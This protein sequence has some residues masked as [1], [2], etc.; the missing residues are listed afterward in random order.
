MP[1]SRAPSEP[2]SPRAPSESANGEPTIVES[3]LDVV[4]GFCIAIAA[5]A[6]SGIVQAQSSPVAWSTLIVCAVILTPFACFAGFV[7]TIGLLCCL[8][9]VAIGLLCAWLPVLIRKACNLARAAA[10]KINSMSEFAEKN[11]V[12]LLG[13]GVMALPLLPVLIVGVAIAG[14]G[15]LCLAPVTVP[16]TLY[17]LYRWNLRPNPVADE[18]AGKASVGNGAA[19]AG[20]GTAA[21]TAAA[22][23]QSSAGER[24]AERRPTQAPIA[25]RRAANPSAGP[26]S[27]RGS[28]RTSAPAARAERSQ[29]PQEPVQLREV[30]EPGHISDH[31]SEQLREVREPRSGHRASAA[32]T[33]LP[34]SASCR[35]PAASCRAPSA[36]CRAQ[37]ASCRAPSASLLSPSPDTTL[38]SPSPAC[39]TEG[40]RSRREGM[41]SPGYGEEDWSET[42]STTRAPSESERAR[43]T[44][45]DHISNHISEQSSSMRPQS[46]HISDHISD[47]ISEQSSSMRPQSH[48]ISDHI[49]D[50]ISEQSSSMRPLAVRLP[51]GCD[52]CAGAP[53]GSANDAAYLASA[54]DAAYLASAV[55]ALAAHKVA[56]MRY[57]SSHHGRASSAAS[58]AFAVAN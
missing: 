30:R 10:S 33:Q 21:G 36:S 3:A 49:S 50:H 27:V 8:P 37:S 39:A 7:M 19:A 51:V 53:N 41:A 35:A 32:V 13:V 45:S 48:H 58:S 56:E 43:L 2:A 40:T 57:A 6:C 9:V 44:P 31:F 29:P 20:N 17:L 25:R 11:P 15:Y 55:R 16:A 38:L 1:S 4:G 23:A 14:I 46:H 5:I 22:A 26:A 42:S 24:R 54:N 47:H 12:V 34:P 18:V 52:V 28:Q